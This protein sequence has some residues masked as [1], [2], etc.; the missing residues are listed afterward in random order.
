MKR[1]LVIYGAGNFAEIAHYYFTQ[2]GRYRVSGF[3]VDAEFAREPTF[4]GLPVFASSELPAE[5]SQHSH[6][7]FVALGIRQLNEIRE[8][9]CQWVEDRG[10]QLASLVCSKAIVADDFVAPPNSM[11]MDGAI[12]HP[13]ARIGRNTIVWNGALIAL[14]CHIGDHCWIVRTTIGEQARIGH[15]TFAGIETAIAPGVGVGAYNIIGTGARVLQDTNDYAVFRP[16]TSTPARAH[17]RKVAHLF[18]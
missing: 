16:C 10:F 9:K 8:S 14:R 5:V 11:V 12:I 17:S 7:F 13:R 4:L 1:G 15:H 2:D 6:D 18:N 3:C